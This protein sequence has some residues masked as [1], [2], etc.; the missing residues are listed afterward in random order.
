[1]SSAG[2]VCGSPRQE[3]R[4]AA[5][6]VHDDP[7]GRRSRRRT[8]SA[9]Q[10]DRP[11]LHR[12]GARVPQLLVASSSCGVRR[13]PCGPSTI[14]RMPG[15]MAVMVPVRMP[16]D[17]QPRLGERRARPR[18]GVRAEGVAGVLQLWVW[19]S[20]PVLGRCWRVDQLDQVVLRRRRSGRPG[21]ACTWM[22]TAKPSTR[23][24]PRRDLAPGGRPLQGRH[25][26]SRPAVPDVSGASPSRQVSG[27]S[28]AGRHA[29]NRCLRMAATLEKIRM[30]STTMT[31]VESWPPTPSWSPR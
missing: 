22:T 30:P 18:R 3:R 20:T 9:D 21:L 12:L 8:R 24:A 23:A 7:R 11:D 17:V 25:S 14:S 15:P 1:M 26:R 16:S 28:S 6:A 31:P 4:R 5:G 13:W 2:R 19:S 27:R 10:P 29:W